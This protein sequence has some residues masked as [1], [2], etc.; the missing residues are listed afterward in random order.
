MPTEPGVDG[1]WE[2]SE[3]RQRA[4]IAAA[5]PAQ[6]L[7]WLEDAIRFAV[8]AGALPRRTEPRSEAPPAPL[9]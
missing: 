5:T 3:R 7:E 8:R 1:G 6:R 2:A 9:D 4:A